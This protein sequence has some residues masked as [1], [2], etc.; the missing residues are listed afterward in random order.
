MVSF[1]FGSLH[2]S[3]LLNPPGSVGANIV[4]NNTW[5]RGL[6]T[7]QAV[8]AV[9]AASLIMTSVSQK[10]PSRV[11][12]STPRS[13]NPGSSQLRHR[14]GGGRHHP[15]SAANQVDESIAP[16]PP[17]PKL[18]RASTLSDTVSEARQ[19]IKSSTDELFLPRVDAGR[20]ATEHEHE[21]AWQST[22]LALALLPA[23]AGI[24]F[25]NGTAVFTDLTLLVLA[26]V[27]L[28]W[29]IRLPW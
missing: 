21:S 17:G 13:N 12:R 8:S 19:S 9:A 14:H 6:C 3:V 23:L 11:P 28:N 27:F 5:V 25:H 24:F 7:A 29:S 2:R 20:H 1:F 16:A 22:P 10:S 18:R 4:T 26:A 15:S